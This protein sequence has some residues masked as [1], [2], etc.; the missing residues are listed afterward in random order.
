M[1]TRLLAL[2]VFLGAAALPMAAQAQ[3]R[4][5]GIQRC[6]RPDGTQVYTDQDCAAFDAAPAPIR[7]ELLARLANDGGGLVRRPEVAGT[8]VPP[9]SPTGQAGGPREAP[10]APATLRTVPDVPG[11]DCVRSPTQLAIELRA[12]WG[13]RD[14]NRI[15]ALY[16]WAGRGTA[17]AASVMSRLQSLLELP[18]QDVRQYGTGDGLVQL[19]SASPAAVGGGLQVSLGDEGGPRPYDFRIVER[20]GCRFIRF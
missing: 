4:G 12:G 14:V 10:A 20:Q 15:A 11:D 13:D 5:T 19:A 8:L 17:E 3:E 9:L 2:L 6:E 18:L 7:G 1:S 16:D